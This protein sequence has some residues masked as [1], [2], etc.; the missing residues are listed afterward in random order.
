MITPQTHVRVT[1]KE[2]WMLTKTDKQLLEIG[3]NNYAKNLEKNADTKTS[4]TDYLN[5]RNAMK[6]YFDYKDA[7]RIEATKQM[8]I[9]P[10][11]GAAFRFFFPMPKSWSDKKRKQMCYTQKKSRPD[12]DNNVKALFDSLLKDDNRISDYR[13]TKFWIDSKSGY[14][15]IEIGS[16][17]PAIG[18]KKIIWEDKIK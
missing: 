17:Q 13:A 1:K 6:K 5:R 18:Y 9:I 16:L 4:P 2:L 8:F 11:Q 3:K 10:E 12:L 7:L 14:I 15:E